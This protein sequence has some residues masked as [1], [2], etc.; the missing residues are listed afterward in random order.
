M[1]LSSFKI[2]GIVLLNGVF[3][4]VIN[5]KYFIHNTFLFAFGNKTNLSVSEPFYALSHPSHHEQFLYTR[6][7]CDAINFWSKN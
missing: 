1:L 7:S 3:S 2:S 6:N 4:F 5:L